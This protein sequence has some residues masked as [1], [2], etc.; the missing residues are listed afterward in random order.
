MPRRF[1]DA[2]V[3]LD[4]SE[5]PR[6]EK[7]NPCCRDGELTRLWVNTGLVDVE[8]TA[9]HVGQDFASFEDYWLPFLLGTGPAGAYAASL[10]EPEAAALRERRRRTLPGSGP[11]GR[12]P[13]VSRAW[14]VSGRVG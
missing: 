13:L 10:A 11:D 14:A 1:W 6:D 7:N 5:E 2:A 9:L 3:A 12:F 4:P 8:A